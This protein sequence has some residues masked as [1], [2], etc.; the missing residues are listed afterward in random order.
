MQD[1]YVG[2]IGDYGK[3]GLLRW[4]TGMR[5][6]DDRG[7]L[8]L[9]INWYLFDEGPLPPNNDGGFTQYLFNPSSAE[10]SLPDCDPTL[11]A[12]MRHIVDA[13]RRYV[14]EVEGSGVLPPDTLY[15]SASLNFDHT[16][17]P[18]RESV[19]QAWLTDGLAALDGADLVF[20]DPDNGLENPRTRRYSKKGPKYTYYDDLPPYWKRGQSLIIYQHAN[21]TIGGI[22]ALVADRCA[23]LR[24]RLPGA[25]PVTLG[26]HR[27]SA[28]VYLIVA[29]P[30]HAGLLDGR[31]HSFLD[32]EWGKGANPHFTRAEC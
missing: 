11:Y 22:E 17:R 25:N 27:S 10:R 15:H 6:V 29:Q 31:I 12:A 8:C 21:H 5:Q 20:V 4:L 23:E 7:G 2:D 24:E 26:F 18:Q 28:R 9:G 13:D 1:R 16:P 3:Y 32:S 30:R 14:A 19:R